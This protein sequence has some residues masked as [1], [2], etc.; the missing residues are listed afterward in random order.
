MQAKPFDGSKLKIARGRRHVAELDAAIITY[1]QDD[2]WVMLL[3]FNTYSSQYGIAVK[4][5]KD[6]PGEF[7]TIFG[8]AVHNFRTALDIL[9][10]DLVALNGVQPEKVYFPFGRDATTFETELKRK[11]GQAPLDIQA[12]VRS[13]RPY[14]GG[15][16][17]LRAL[18]DLDITDKH[19]AVMGIGT[20]AQTGPLPMRRIEN[21]SLPEGGGRMVFEAAFDAM[22]T[23][24]IDLTGFPPNPDGART[25]GKIAYS[26]LNCVL[27]KGLPLGGELV[28]K[29][30]NQMGDTAESIVQ[31]FETHCL[32]GQKPAA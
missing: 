21:R 24:P 2:P 10:N 11:M 30:L 12:V 13:F 28:V 31:T 17:T 32:G 6:I 7:S 20:G 25:I 8:D 15:N 26:Q 5:R 22:K 23:V 1:F 14:T 29:A 19:I 4:G 18:H 9:A 27:L 16:E 3:V